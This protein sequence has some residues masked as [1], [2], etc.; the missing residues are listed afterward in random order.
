MGS[1]MLA[2][3]ALLF[4]SGALASEPEQFIMMHADPALGTHIRARSF[5]LDVPPAKNY[6]DLTE[7]Q[8]SRVRAKYPPMTDKDEPPYPVGGVR[9]LYTVLSDVQHYFKT[10]GELDMV[11]TVKVDGSVK[12]VSVFKTPDWKMMEYAAQVLAVQ[13]FKPALCDGA[14]CEMDYP[15]RMTMRR[16]QH[17]GHPSTVH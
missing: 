8:K 2:T 16:K 6:A 17:G 10:A 11:A 4:S 14:P 1:I 9:E 3:A 13:K 5:V 15:V 12:V 7:Q